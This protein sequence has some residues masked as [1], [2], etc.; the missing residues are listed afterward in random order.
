[1]PRDI[2]ICINGVGIASV[3]MKIIFLSASL[4]FYILTLAVLL[5]FWCSSFTFIT[6]SLLFF[7]CLQKKFDF[8]IIYRFRFLYILYV[9]QNFQTAV[10]M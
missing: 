7:C 3:K 2:N 4:V 8:Y 9:M 6:S 1:L 5:C 10:K